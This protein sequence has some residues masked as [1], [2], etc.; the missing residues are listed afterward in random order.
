MSSDPLKEEL[1]GLLINSL[2]A[3][4]AAAVQQMQLDNFLSQIEITRKKK[5][6]EDRT[7]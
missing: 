2:R 6:G 7:E 5:D 1:R 4:V 3:N